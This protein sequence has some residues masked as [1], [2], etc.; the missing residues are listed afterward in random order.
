MNPR[1]ASRA[2]GTPHELVFWY[3]L[4]RLLDLRLRSSPLPERREAA[5]DIRFA[6]LRRAGRAFVLSTTAAPKRRPWSSPV[7]SPTYYL[8][9]R[10]SCQATITTRPE[11]P[12]TSPRVQC[13]PLL[14][15]LFA[16]DGTMFRALS[17]VRATLAAHLTRWITEL[18]GPFGLG[19][20]L[21]LPRRSP[22]G[23]KILVGLLLT[24][25]DR[26]QSMRIAACR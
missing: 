24:G 4:L 22:R 14:I 12:C 16:R 18:A 5:L 11:L 15:P 9:W 21:T 26:S 17:P 1:L 10:S 20:R 13:R 19:A 25:R 23:T 8:K 6:S 3:G 2:C 7:W